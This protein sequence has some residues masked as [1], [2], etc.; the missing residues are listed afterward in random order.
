MVMYSAVT[1]VSE[2]PTGIAGDRFGRGRVRAVGLGASA[3][4]AALI[5]FSTAVPVLFMAFVLMAF[6]TAS[7][8]GAAEAWYVDTVDGSGDN[9][10]DPSHVSALAQATSARNLGLAA[11]AAIA[12]VFVAFNRYVLDRAI[13]GTSLTG[14]FLLVIAA[15]IVDAAITVLFMQEGSASGSR[16]RSAAAPRSKEGLL[17]LA[18]TSRVPVTIVAGIYFVLGVLLAATEL[19]TPT[20]LLDA[21][22]FATSAMTLGALICVARLVASGMAQLGPTLA[23]RAGSPLRAAGWVQA[24]AALAAFAAISQTTLGTIVVFFGIYVLSAPIMVLTATELHQHVGADHRNTLL[25]T[26]SLAAMTGAGLMAFLI[27]VSS[28]SPVTYG[29]IASCAVAFSAVPAVLYRRSAPG[30]A[31]AAPAS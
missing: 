8:S 21:N 25:S 27:S 15:L 17:A 23:R 13:T 2:V 29:V 30:R 3:V 5:A 12:A 9:V 14:V 28:L 18:P 10:D 11:G 19:L 4:G 26:M 24:V 1:A 7:L 22:D 31:S 6:G 16:S 20:R